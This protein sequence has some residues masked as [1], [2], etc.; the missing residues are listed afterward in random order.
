M[1]SAW[2]AWA[3]TTTSSNSSVSQPSALT[4][5]PSG[6]RSIVRTGAPVRIR[7]ANGRVISSTYRR[8]PPVTVRHCGRPVKPSMP[9]LWKKRARKAAGKD[10]ICSGSADHTAEAWATIRRSVNHSP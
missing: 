5:T 4:S 10:H 3:A 7:S 6:V 9:W 8:E 1:P 2:S